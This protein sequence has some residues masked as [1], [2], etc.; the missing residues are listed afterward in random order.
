MFALTPVWPGQSIETRVTDWHGAP[1]G[2]VT[3]QLLQGTAHI[4]PCENFH[5]TGGAPPET[6][7][8]VKYDAPT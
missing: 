6:F 1:S 2:E 7:P 8:N 5:R 3:T 4:V